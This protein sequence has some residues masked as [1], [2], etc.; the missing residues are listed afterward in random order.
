MTPLSKLCPACTDKLHRLVDDWELLSEIV[1]L[2]E[3]TVAEGIILATLEA[4]KEC[5]HQCAD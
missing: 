3:I 2:D 1:C 4:M 5:Q